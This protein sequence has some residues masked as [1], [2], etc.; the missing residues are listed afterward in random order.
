MVEGMSLWCVTFQ[1]PAGYCVYL[2][3]SLA[4]MRSEV[5]AAVVCYQCYDKG[6]RAHEGAGF[7]EI[8]ARD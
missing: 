8:H 7:T 2:L 5:A 4:E 3:L 1:A 6:D